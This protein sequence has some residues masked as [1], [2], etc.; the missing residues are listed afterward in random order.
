MMDTRSGD[1]TKLSSV[2]FPVEDSLLFQFREAERHGI[3]TNKWFLSQQV[4]K[5]VGWDYA[6][7]DWI[8]AGHRA[9]WLAAMRA[10]GL[11]P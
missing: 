3:E 10:S 9:R 2:A 7:W 6:Q 5:D 1:S 11:A 8:V 4:G